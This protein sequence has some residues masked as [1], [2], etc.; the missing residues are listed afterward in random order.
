MGKKSWVPTMRSRSTLGQ[1]LYV[2]SFFVKN[3]EFHDFERSQLS[4]HNSDR[5]TIFCFRISAS[6][7]IKLCKEKKKGKGELKTS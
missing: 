3:P 1:R 4:N 6:N 5:K 7:S 2:T